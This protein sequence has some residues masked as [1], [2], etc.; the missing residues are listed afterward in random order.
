MSQQYLERDLLRS[1]V[2]ANPDITPAQLL[3]LLEPHFR[4]IVCG[5]GLDDIDDVTSDRDEEDEPPLTPEQM[6][7]A[8]DVYAR[9]FDWVPCHNDLREAIDDVRAGKTEG[10]EKYT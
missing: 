8:L 7:E 6:V 10:G 4:P 9:R 2:R 3:T 1:W 5:V